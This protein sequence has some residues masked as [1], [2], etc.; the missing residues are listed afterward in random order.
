MKAFMK[1][2][3]CLC[4]ITI[5]IFVT[6][7]WLNRPITL[8]MIIAAGLIA[9]YIGVMWASWFPEHDKDHVLGP[10]P[11]R[12]IYLDPSPEQL[13]VYSD[14][15]I[16]GL[17]GPEWT[18]IHQ[19]R[20]LRSTQ[21]RVD[22]AA[23]RTPANIIYAVTRPGRHG[24]CFAAVEADGQFDELAEL[25]EGFVTSHG[26]FVNRWEAYRIADEADQLEG[27][28]K[29]GNMGMLHSEDLW[30]NKKQ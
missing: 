3:C 20:L 22:F 14:H 11:M 10:P 8:G 23:V 27:R 18:F 25:A 26:R 5:V 19:F 15:G 21:E 16:L 1:W 30:T 24:T 9:I 6:S 7:D 4:V 28:E 2:F 12:V 17:I 29:T 13:T